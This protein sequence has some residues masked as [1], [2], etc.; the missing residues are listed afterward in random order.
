[1]CGVN[2]VHHKCFSFVFTQARKGATSIRMRDT[3]ARTAHGQIRRHRMHSRRFRMRGKDGRL[4]FGEASRSARYAPLPFLPYKWESCACGLRLPYPTTFW[5]RLQRDF[6]SI[7]HCR[8]GR[9]H[10]SSCRYPPK[11]TLLRS[12]RHTQIPDFLTFSVACE[13]IK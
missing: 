9:L 4:P 2:T 6:R 12:R 5:N 3:S 13:A 1:M 7:F 8:H 10:G 11:S